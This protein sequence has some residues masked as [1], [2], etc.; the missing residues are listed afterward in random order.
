M[1]Y[2]RLRHLFEG[3]IYIIPCPP[4]LADGSSNSALLRSLIEIAAC[5]LAE[6]HHAGRQ[7]LPSGGYQPGDA[8]AAQERGEDGRILAHAPDAASQSH[9]E[10]QVPVGVQWGGSTSGYPP[11]DAG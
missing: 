11:V 2:M 1:V 3:T 6:A 4:M 9:L 7:L 5:G 10:Q 8:P